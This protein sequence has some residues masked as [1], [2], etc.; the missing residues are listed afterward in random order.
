MH[1]YYSSSI[2]APS[3]HKFLDSVKIL[4]ILQDAVKY[5]NTITQAY[6]TINRETNYGELFTIILVLICKRGNSST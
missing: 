6:E 5:N 1:K 4:K 3:H 2:E